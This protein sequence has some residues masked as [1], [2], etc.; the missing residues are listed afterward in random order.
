VD[1]ENTIEI[2]VV[3]EDG[4]NNNTYVINIT[5]NPS[6]QAVIEDLNIDGILE[7][8]ETPD[9]EYN[10]LT[11]TRKKSSLSFDN[12]YGAAIEV[13]FN[14]TVLGDETWYYL[15]FVDG[16][17]TIEITVV[18]E[19]GENNNTYVINITR[20]PSSQA[21]IEN[22]NIDGILEYVETPVFE[23]DNLTT[24]RKKSSLSF[25]NLYGAA[26][27][28]KFNNAVL[29]DGTYTYYN[30]NFAPG[31]NIVE[32]KVVSE[33]RENT[34]IYVINITRNLSSQAVIQ[35]LSIEDALEY[36]ETPLFEYDNLTT[37]R[38][39][40]YLDFDNPYGATTEM[41][42]NGTFL[43]KGT[44]YRLNFAPGGNIVE[45]KVTS[46]NGENTN[47]YTIN[48]TRNLSSQALIEYLSI[49][50]IFWADSA[51]EFEY[52]EITKRTSKYNGFCM[53]FAYGHLNFLTHFV[54]NKCRIV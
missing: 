21:V 11:T 51:E 29:G 34:N 35:G 39:T 54:I 33:D 52:T 31:E 13:K 4:E 41:R 53:I 10:N 42:L 9:F 28:V 7:Y 48:I 3:S 19:D 2:T 18:S 47:I 23:Y 27:E 40:S 15:N 16:E 36:I 22:L 12:P 44:F 14:N 46:S 6:S 37:T 25:D 38:K 8:V 32:I 17:N 49:D 30:L 50:D 26:I 45:I 5:R 1:G 43:G 20:N 24:T